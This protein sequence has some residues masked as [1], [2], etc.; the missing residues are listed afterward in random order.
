M[1]GVGGCG[2]GR[3]RWVDGWRP[4][5]GGRGVVA[6]QSGGKRAGY[7]MGRGWWA[8]AGA[9][10]MAM[11]MAAAMEHVG[12]RPVLVLTNGH[13]WVGAETGPL[14]KEYIF[15]ETTALD[16]S[17]QEA[18]DIAEQNWKFLQEGNLPYSLVN[19]NELRAEKVLPIRYE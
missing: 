19:V 3:E 18:M 6:E 10:A 9:M 4:T 17:P 1:V 5:A 14:S 7:G 2:R 13:A 12:L 8:G 16:K 11:L 15:I